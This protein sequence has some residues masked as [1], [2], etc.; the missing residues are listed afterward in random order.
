MNETKSKIGNSVDLSTTETLWKNLHPI[1]LSGFMAYENDI[2][3]GG[4]VVSSF[5]N[6]INE[7]GIAR[8]ERD[9]SAKLYS[10]DLLKWQIIEW[11][12]EKKFRY[13]DLSGSNPDSTNAKELG[14]YRYKQKWGGN[15]VRY[16]TISI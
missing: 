15:L 14:I 7:W 2:P 12:L 9:T 3:I 6:Y 5:N 8:S 13:Y 10:Q 16:S 4:I 1:G 11:G